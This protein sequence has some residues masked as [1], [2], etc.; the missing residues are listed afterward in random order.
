MTP[1]YGSAGVIDY[2]GARG[3]TK[4][5]RALDLVRGRVGL[6]RSAVA[7]QYAPVADAIRRREPA[8]VL[9]HNAPVL[10]WL[11]RDTEHRV[12][13]YAHN[14]LLRTYSRLEAGRVLDSAAA[15]VCVSDSLAER[16]RT[17]LPRKLAERVHVVRNGIDCVRFAPPPNRDGAAPT[18]RN[19]RMRVMFVG[20]MIAEK[21]P[22]V[23]IRA[24]QHLA[25]PDV[26]YFL[27]GSQ[28]FARDAPLSAY[29]QEL[30][31]L[32]AEATAESGADIRFEPFVDRSSLPDLL[33]SADLLVVPSR[34]AEP[35]GLTAAEGLATG[36]PVIVSR[37]GGLPDVVG[38]A[39]VLVPPDDPAA[40]ADA[41]AVLADDPDARWRMSQRARAHALSHDWSWAW[42]NLRQVLEEL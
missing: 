31:R 25:R 7:R 8:F 5:E 19:A 21:G 23:L 30:R 9:A 29:E 26:E 41:I 10:P 32:A 20:R 1:R 4:Y 17:A 13:L 35:S 37:V 6:S 22:D 28:G 42:S 36:V 34:W 16:T 3:P 12:V 38:S 24:A 40:L 14:D 39:G 11:L 18:T 2:T 27:V 15:I 33:R